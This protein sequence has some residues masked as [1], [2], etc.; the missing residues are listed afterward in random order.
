[1]QITDAFNLPHGIG[2]K[3]VERTWGDLGTM[4]IEKETFVWVA[5]TD[6]DYPK[7]LESYEHWRDNRET[8]EA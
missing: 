3:H 4:P 2:L 8:E 5:V 1:M 6:K 7:A